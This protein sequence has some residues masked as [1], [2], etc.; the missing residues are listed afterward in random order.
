MTQRPGIHLTMS[1]TIELSARLREISSGR[2]CPV[3]IDKLRDLQAF[4]VADFDG[5]TPVLT[6]RLELNK[7]AYRARDIGEFTPLKLEEST[8]EVAIRIKMCV[9]RIW[10]ERR[11]AVHHPKPSDDWFELTRR[12]SHRTEVGNTMTPMVMFRPMRTMAPIRDPVLTR[13]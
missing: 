4:E 7:L 8:Q 3:V 1:A 2:E 10:I 9:R 12:L 5:L 11:K 6:R 13:W